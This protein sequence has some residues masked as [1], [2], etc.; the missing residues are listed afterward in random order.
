[1]EKLLLATMASLVFLSSC[2]YTEMYH[3][4]KDDVEWLS[5]YKEG[6]VCLFISD[7][8]CCVDSLIVEE[9]GVFDTY[10]PF[11]RNEGH[12]TM[13]ACGYM[14][15][16][17]FHNDRQRNFLLIHVE[18]N[19]PDVLELYLK[20][21]NRLLNKG[22]MQNPYLSVR[23]VCGKL[24]DDV[25]VVD[26]CVSFLN[27]SSYVSC[28]YFIWSKSK[29]LIQ[30]K[31]ENGAVYNLYKKLPGRHYVKPLKYTLSGCGM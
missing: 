21:G 10:N 31:Y 5:V 18:K 14:R 24:Y 26:S 28:E 25:I 7:D 19:H 13:H 22:L 3:F 11:M 17:V 8:G 30:Y 12:S 2:I 23:E 29:G 20:F 9:K 27:D 4:D 1:M 6:D 15:S 16:V